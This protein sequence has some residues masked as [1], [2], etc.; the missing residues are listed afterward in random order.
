MKFTKLFLLAFILVSQFE[1][2][3]TCCSGGVPLSNSI[4][5]PF[6][7]KGATQFGVFY[8]FNNLNTLNE[9]SRK[10]DD[11]SRKRIT[12]SVLF[13]F[14]YNFSDRIL[15]E[16]LF[17][18]VN[19]QREINQF[20]NVNFDQTKGIGDGILLMRYMFFNKTTKSFSLGFG[21]KIPLGSTEEVNSQGILLNADLQ[22]GSNAFDYIFTSTYT[23]TFEFR[24]SM[25]LV[26]RSIYR[27]TGDNNSYLNVSTYRFGRELQFFGGVSDLVLVGSQ[28]FEINMLFKYRNTSQDQINNN[29]VAN[30][31]GEWIFFNPTISYVVSPDLRFSTRVDVPMYSKVTGLQLT[32]TFRIN[33]GVSLRLSK[34]EKIESEI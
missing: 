18:W 16:G 5:L 26:L 9:G 8:D 27:L 3:Q 23:S 19:Q 24:K 32:P 29:I 10:L 14:S 15:L 30:T 4:G 34:K 20:G 33:L 7:E 22:P 11:R 6:L 13:N 2:S 12:H 31:G 21:G 25:S 28:L 17:T 1:F